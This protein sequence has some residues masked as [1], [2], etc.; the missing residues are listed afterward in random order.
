MGPYRRI[1]PARAPEASAPAEGVDPIVTLAQIRE[2]LSIEDGEET[3]LLTQLQANARPAIELYIGRPVTPHTRRY[4]YATAPTGNDLL[5]LPDTPVRSVTQ[6]VAVGSDGVEAPFPTPVVIGAGEVLPMGDVEIAPPAGTT[7][8][9][10]ATG[11]ALPYPV[12]VDC[13]VG[14]TTAPLPIVQGAL[15]AI[16]EWHTE[17]RTRAPYPTFTVPHSAGALLDQYRMGPVYFA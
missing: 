17:R 11:S 4:R 5:I 3:D 7:W 9:W 15:A 8:T 12:A 1:R 2:H 14:W 6:V 10:P 16:A 13:E